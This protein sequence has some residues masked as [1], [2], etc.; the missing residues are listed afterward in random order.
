MGIR[1]GFGEWRSVNQ[2]GDVYV[3]TYL[4]DR[5]HGIGRYCWADGALY[6]GYFDKDQK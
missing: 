6:E 2:G 5:K 1:T 4:K 3:G